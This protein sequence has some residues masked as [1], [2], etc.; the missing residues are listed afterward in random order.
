MR[1]LAAGIVGVSPPNFRLE[2]TPTPRSGTSEEMGTVRSLG[3]PT[4]V[5]VYAFRSMSFTLASAVRLVYFSYVLQRKIYVVTHK[6]VLKSRKSILHKTT[7][8][9]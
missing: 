5:G 1:L 8:V 6:L 7:T 9:N 3:V 2:F 4:S